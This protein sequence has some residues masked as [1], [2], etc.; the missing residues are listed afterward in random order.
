[1]LLDANTDIMGMCVVFLVQ[2]LRCTAAG[3]DSRVGGGALTVRDNSLVFSSF[4]TV[5]Y[6]KLPPL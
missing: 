5:D 1:M 6:C 3:L 2:Y 4:R